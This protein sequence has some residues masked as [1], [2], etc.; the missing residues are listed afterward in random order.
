MLFSIFVELDRYKSP[1]STKVWLAG[2]VNLL[3]L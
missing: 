3:R 1:P 2:G